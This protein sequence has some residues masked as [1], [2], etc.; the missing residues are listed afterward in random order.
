[1]NIIPVSKLVSCFNVDELSRGTNIILY[2]FVSNSIEHGK[3][4]SCSRDMIS[5]DIAGLNKSFTINQINNGDIVIYIDNEI[6]SVEDYAREF[7]PC[8]LYQIQMIVNALE[9]Q[10]KKSN[11]FVGLNKCD[12]IEKL[13]SNIEDVIDL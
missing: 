8:K 13:I 7:I 3:V 12:M 5:C 2:D 10:L 4:L 1:M 9:I 6:E 11:D